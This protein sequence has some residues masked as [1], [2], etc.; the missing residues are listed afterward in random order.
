MTLEG[1]GLVCAGGVNQSYLAR[2]P[3]LLGRLGP[4]KASS[5]RVARQIAN[6]LRTGEAASHYSTFETCPVIWPF[7]PEAD[8]DRILRDLVAQIPF[9]ETRRRTMVVLCDCVRDSLAA[10]IP[11]PAGARG[12]SLNVIPGS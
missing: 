6:T 12:V 9:Q 2:M 5:Y 10:R 7:V 8:L 3:A 4:I 11:R 1:M